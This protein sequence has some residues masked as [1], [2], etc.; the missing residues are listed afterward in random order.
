MAAKE[1]K[2]NLRMNILKRVREAEIEE[3][4]EESEPEP[5]KK[6]D[7][8]GRD[9]NKIEKVFLDHEKKLVSTSRLIISS[10]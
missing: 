10:S 2:A 9:K 6:R 8:K 3:N 4:Q 5:T 1:T 7:I